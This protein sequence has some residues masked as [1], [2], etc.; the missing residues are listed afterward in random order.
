MWCSSPRCAEGRGVRGAAARSSQQKAGSWWRGSLSGCRESKG[1]QRVEMPSDKV[2]VLWR[3]TAHPYWF[4]YN[5]P[6][7]PSMS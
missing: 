5:V 4:Y 7:V 6:A 3:V 1:A 2:I